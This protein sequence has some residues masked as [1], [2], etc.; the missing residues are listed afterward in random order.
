MSVCQ[1]CGLPLF[2]ANKPCHH[3]K[4]LKPDWDRLIAVTDYELPLTKLIRQFKSHHKVELAQALARLMFL[5]W[6]KEKSQSHLSKPDIVTC[7]PLHHSRY[8][9]RG[10]NQSELLAKPISYWIGSQYHPYLL[11]RSD[12]RQDQKALSKQNRKH[13]IY[14]AF[15]CNTS[16]SGKTIAVIDDIVT[17][18][19]TMNEISR[20]L[21]L[22]GAKHIHVICLCRTSL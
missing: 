9:S 11:K 12:K 21:K 10:Y 22:Q 20:V 16:L 14:R 3:C 13:N 1:L 18:G 7:V 17:T 15:S 19:N 6:L 5:S 8:W 2:P 4:K